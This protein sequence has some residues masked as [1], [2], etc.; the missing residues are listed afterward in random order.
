MKLERHVSEMEGD[1]SF[2]RS[3][4]NSNLHK[5]LFFG[6][7]YLHAVLDGR[8]NYGSLGWN[9]YQGFD[10]SDFEISDLQ[11]QSFMRMEFKD[12]K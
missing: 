5:N 2:R 9:V 4:H 6:L 1:S 11:L 3:L 12:Q 7:C 10:S 8:K